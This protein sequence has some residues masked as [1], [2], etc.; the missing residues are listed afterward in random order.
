MSQLCEQSSLCF[1]KIFRAYLSH[2]NGKLRPDD[3]TLT[4]VLTKM[5]SEVDQEHVYI[6]IDALDECPDNSGMPTPREEVLKL[7][8]SL[9]DLP[10]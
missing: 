7:V 2:G 1:D 9:V 10:L 3:D 8:E 6:I 4:N 5:L